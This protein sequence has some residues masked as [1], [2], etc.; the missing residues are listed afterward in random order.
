MDYNMKLA[1]QVCF[2]AYNVSRLFAQFYEK[3]LKSFGLT[4]SQYLVLLSLWEENPQTLHSIG[5]KLD[6]SSNTLTPLL[7]RLEQSGWVTRQKSDQDKRQL[8]VSLTQ[9][10][11]EQKQPIYDAISKCVSEDM[12]LDLYKQTKDIMDQLEATLRKQLN[13]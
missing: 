9:K 6:L 7:K 11:K 4:Y 8:V 12:N 10:G 5:H 13:K 1:N 2:S 3:E